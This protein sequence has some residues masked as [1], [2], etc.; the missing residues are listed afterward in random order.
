MK[1]IDNTTLAVIQLSDDFLW[2]DEHKWIPTSGKLTYTLTGALLTELSTK[3]AGRPITLG[4]EKE[5]AWVTRSDLA[6][7]RTAASNPV[8]NFTLVLEY[9][10]DTRQ[11]KVVFR[12]HENPIEAE[13]VKGFQSHSQDDWFNV[14]IRLMEVL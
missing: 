2:Q 9:A 1:L 10:T 3:Q 12:H 7:L 14:T 13:P 11:F 8:K 6:L 5:M 4:A